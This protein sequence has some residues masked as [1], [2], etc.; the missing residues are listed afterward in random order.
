MLVICRLTRRVMAATAGSRV[1]DEK[2]GKIACFGKNTRNFDVSRAAD[3]LSFA[4]AGCRNP[5]RNLSRKG[6]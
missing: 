2:E 3:C 5:I 4:N 6:S 1:K